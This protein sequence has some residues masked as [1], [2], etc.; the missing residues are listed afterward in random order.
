MNK[1]ILFC[2]LKGGVGKT[3]LCGL[4][5][6]YAYS[7][8]LPIVV[9]DADIQQSLFRHRQRE[10]SEHSLES[11]PWQLQPLNTATPEYVKSVM[12]RLK[13]IPS[14]VI[15]D[16]PGNINDPA[17]QY[18]YKAA[19]IAVIPT[20]YDSDNLDATNL[21]ANVFQKASPAHI[22][23]IP[24]NIVII[25]ERR[26]EVL[27]ARECAYDMLGKYGIITPRIKQS[28]VVKC[29]STLLP[30]SSYQRNAV[31]FSFDPIIDMI[32]I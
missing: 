22:V 23:F 3:T 11:A 18:I 31:K 4:F 21:F 9:L 14:L 8:G 10:L 17:L 29:Y 27:L 12:E 26:E 16:C 1:I 6:Q 20:R 13:Q 30:L 19:D 5:S 7:M 32:K 24:N 15:I 28:V 2:N 25:E